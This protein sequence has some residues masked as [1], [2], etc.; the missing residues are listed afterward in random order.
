MGKA[1]FETIQEILPNNP[2]SV[3]GRIKCNFELIE[4]IL[5]ASSNPLKKGNINL[6]DLV[7]EN[8]FAVQVPFGKQGRGELFLRAQDS[9]QI[10]EF[11][12]Y[13]WLLNFGGY[14]KGGKIYGTRDESG[15]V[16][17]RDNMIVDNVKVTKKG[18]K[19]LETLTFFHA[20][21][22]DGYRIR[23]KRSEIEKKHLKRS[24]K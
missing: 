10:Q 2:N 1:D 3:F 20:M 24:K 14:I 15:K 9:R 16:S 17:L 5:R 7:C 22:V 13:I 19:L 8:V 21:I 11:V 12:F 18:E 6:I 23:N 4:K